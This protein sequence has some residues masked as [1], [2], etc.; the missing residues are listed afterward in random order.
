MTNIH[1]PHN[2]VLQKKF[3]CSDDPFSQYVL[4]Q[5]DKYINSVKNTPLNTKKIEIDGRLQVCRILVQ[6]YY[7]DKY[8][9]CESETLY[10]IHCEQIIDKLLIRHNYDVEHIIDKMREISPPY[11]AYRKEDGANDNHQRN[12]RSFLYRFFLN[13][14]SEGLELLWDDEKW[15][16]QTCAGVPKPDLEITLK[17]YIEIWLTSMIEEPMDHKKQNAGRFAANTFLREFMEKTHKEDYAQIQD[18]TT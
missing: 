9:D 14:E 1:A 15:L 5:K 7:R 17:R 8:Q 10:Q 16:E 3:K 2:W 18:A 11:R 13:A 6:R 4:S 12:K